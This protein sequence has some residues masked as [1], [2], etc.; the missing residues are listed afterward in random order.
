MRKNNILPPDTFVR[1]NIKFIRMLGKKATNVD[2]VKM[3]RDE[4]VRQH[5]S[6]GCEPR[7]S[8]HADF[9]RR[10]LISSS[11]TFKALQSTKNSSA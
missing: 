11:L 1:D 10:A 3:V 9:L 6:V 8:I 4:A 7:A 2:I 5:I